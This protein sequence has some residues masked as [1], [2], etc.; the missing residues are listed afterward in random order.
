VSLAAVRRTLLVAG[1]AL[2]AGPLVGPALPIAAIFAAS[3]AWYLALVLFAGAACALIARAAGRAVAV[4]VLALGLAAPIVLTAVPVPPALGVRLPCPRNW[5]WLPTWQLRSSPMGSVEFSVAGG[6][7][8][9]CYGRPAARG[10]TMLGGRRI[11]YGRLWRTGANEPTTI[12]TPMA[13]EVAD[14]TVPAGRASLYTIPGP[15]SWEVILN[16]STAQWGIESEYNPQV[17]AEELGRA[18][19]RSE[20]VATPVERLT[21]VP[22]SHADGSVDL[23]LAWETTRVRIPVR[24]AHR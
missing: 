12:I 13:L 20:R 5:G 16:R 21:F 6:P 10:R 1:L 3:A 17:R 18:I 15:E 24:R 9:L 19:V 14:V 22:D 23:I 11:P 2:L 4:A 7:V 8:K